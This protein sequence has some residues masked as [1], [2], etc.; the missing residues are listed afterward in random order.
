M[1]TMRRIRRKMRHRT[2]VRLVVS[3]GAAITSRFPPNFPRSEI[4]YGRLRDRG[5]IACKR[6]K[7]AFRAALF[8]QWACLAASVRSVVLDDETVV[9]NARLHP[10]E[11]LHSI[12]GH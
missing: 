10:L 4:G 5:A 11:P 1:A 9:G 6:N 12:P 3:N 7:G 8:R 2:E